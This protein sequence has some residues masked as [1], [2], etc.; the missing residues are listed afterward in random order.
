MCQECIP[1]WLVHV[2]TGHRMKCEHMFVLVCYY[3]TQSILKHFKTIK[4][5]FN[6]R[7][8]ILLR[9]KYLASHKSGVVH[10][11]GFWQRMAG[12]ATAKAK[13]HNA[14]IFLFLLLLLNPNNI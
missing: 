5:L 1:Q 3:H 13:R 7:K 4:I 14:F 9:R 12:N 11:T 2:D 10:G 6:I 8:N